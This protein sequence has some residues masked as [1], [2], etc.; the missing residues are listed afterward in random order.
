MVYNVNLHTSKGWYDFKRGCVA[1]VTAIIS[2]CA[3]QDHLHLSENNLEE[4][5]R[6]R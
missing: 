1:A 5:C 6:Y 2:G 4:N 3:A